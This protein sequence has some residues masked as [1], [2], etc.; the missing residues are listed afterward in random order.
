MEKKYKKIC[1]AFISEAKYNFFPP[2]LSIASTWTFTCSKFGPWNIHDRL[3]QRSLEIVSFQLFKRQ[4]YHYL[5]ATALM[6]LKC[7]FETFKF[8]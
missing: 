3:K 6:N 7:P 2:G 1:Q 5:R 4:H 8:S